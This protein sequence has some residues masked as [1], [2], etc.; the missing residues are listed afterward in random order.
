[1]LK[2]I[3]PKEAHTIMNYNLSQ[4]QDKEEKKVSIFVSLKKLIGLIGK[5]RRNFIMAF[6]AIVIN[7]IL[8]LLGPYLVGHTI[9]TYIQTKQYNGVLLFSGIILCLYIVAFFVNYSQM[10]MMGG[11]GQRMLYS[12]RNALFNKLQELPVDFFNQNK[13]GD[14]ISRINNDTDKVNQFFSQSLMQFI[15]SI[16]TMIGAGIFLLSINLWVGLAA[17]TP[18]IIVW[19]ITKI[20]SPW[21]KK[22]N[23]ESMKSTGFLSAEIQESLANFKVIIAFDRS[24][25]FRKRF[26]IANKQ[27]YTNSI[28]SGIANN[29]FTPIY[30]LAAN[31]GQLIV[32]AFGI[33]LILKGY[34]TIMLADWQL[35]QVFQLGNAN[36]TQ[37]RAGDCITWE[38]QDIPH[39]TCNMGW[40]D[41]PML[42]ITGCTTPATQQVLDNAGPDQIFDLSM[43]K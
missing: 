21:V 40:W 6:G 7:A 9:D 22:R 35:G 28:K 16:I 32:L 12:L 31:L 10:L 23:A 38:W 19:V 15:G 5:E 8:S 39:A 14:L 24:D 33:F 20:L 42:Q 26:E 2:L 29:V 17:L 30:T 37:W 27:N 41:R 36:W 34:F 13:V 4:N 1:M 18:A 11:I 3:T 25:Y 43:F